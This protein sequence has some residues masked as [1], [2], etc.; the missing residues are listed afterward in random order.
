MAC[1][2][3]LL[4]VPYEVEPDTLRLAYRRLAFA[5]HPD[6]NPN[7]PQAA[8]KFRAVADAY[9]HILRA[10]GQ[11]PP[12]DTRRRKKP[13]RKPTPPPPPPRTPTEPIPPDLP[14]YWAGRCVGD[15]VQG[16]LAGFSDGPWGPFDAHVFF[17]KA[18][19]GRVWAVNL[20]LDLE[21]K[22]REVEPGWW[23]RVELSFIR[24]HSRRGVPTKV[25][26][27]SACPV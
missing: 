26:R 22:L 1:P 16:V 8:E 10:I 27:V 20:T 23:V 5:V 18:D 9:A 24:E 15:F 14:V 4:G 3:A 12:P 13:R 11:R 7:D 17:V 2:Y 6:R 19:D 21:P 25:F